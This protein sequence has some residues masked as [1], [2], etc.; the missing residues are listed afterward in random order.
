MSLPSTESVL[1]DWRYGQPQ[2]ERLCAALMHIEGFE[3]IDPQHPLG[4]PDETKDVIAIKNSKK[5]VGAAYF[6]PTEKSFNEIKKKFS[7]DFAGVA[8]NDASAF[9]F[10]VN[11]HLSVTERKELISQADQ[12]ETEL[13]HLERLASLLDAPKGC[14]IRLQYL[15]IPM[16]EEEQWAFWNSMN[17][18]VVRKLVQ[19]E[20]S[21]QSIHSKLDLVLARTNTLLANLQQSPSSLLTQALVMDNGET[22]TASLSISMLCWLHRIVTEGTTTPESTRGRLRSV[23]VWIGPPG[24]SPEAATFVPPNDFVH[25]LF[26]LLEWWKSGYASLRNNEKQ[27]VIHALAEFHHRFLSL[28]PFLD[29][30]GRVARILLD[31]AARELLNSGIG[32]ELVSDAVAYLNCL[33]AADQGNM[34][35]LTGL[36]AA[37]LR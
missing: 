10:F 5:W 33:K 21:L 28:H 22:P 30:N 29:A 25:P 3:S 37:S 32:A 19:N 2:A 1:H 36:I 16:T 18:D 9:A 27:A 13:Y 12:I 15:R 35:P 11:Q 17:Y 26:E 24:S 34:Q 6:P 4:G 14:G 23:A 7:D 8:K 31:Q 20:S